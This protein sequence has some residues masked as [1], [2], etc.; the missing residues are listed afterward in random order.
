MMR[1]ALTLDG[2]PLFDSGEHDP[3]RDAV[4]ALASFWAG[5]DDD[6]Q[7]RFFQEV[8]VILLRN[9]PR[10]YNQPAYIGAHM[11]RCACI[12]PEGRDFL[13]MVAGAMDKAEQKEGLK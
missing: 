12:G 7:A 10:G 11:A 8:G 13:R 9:S 2:E 4:K 5:L 3:G 6:A 1:L